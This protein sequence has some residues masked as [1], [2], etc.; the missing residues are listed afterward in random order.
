VLST[1]EDE[2][3]EVVYPGFYSHVVL[4]WRSPELFWNLLVSLA[5]S[6]G[7]QIQSWIY[8]TSRLVSKYDDDNFKYLDAR[9]NR[10]SILVIPNPGDHRHRLFVPPLQS[11]NAEPL[12]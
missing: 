12:V 7:G 11:W 9:Q 2:G 10:L 8:Y 5:T 4:F 6:I 3:I 1:E